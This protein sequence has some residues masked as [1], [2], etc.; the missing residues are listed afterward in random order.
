MQDAARE[1]HVVDALLLLIRHGE[2]GDSEAALRMPKKHSTSL[3]ALQPPGE[4]QVALDQRV[5]RGFHK[6]FPLVKS[7]RTGQEFRFC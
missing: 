7:E 2:L 4:E 5:L 3:H 1:K 6:N